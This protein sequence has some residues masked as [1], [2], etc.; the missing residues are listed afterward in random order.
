MRN[1]TKKWM[2]AVVVVSMVLGMYSVSSKTEA[3]GKYWLSGVSKPAGGTM[4]MYYK[5]NA[6]LI[7]GK[8]AIADIATRKSK[9]LL[10]KSS[11]K[12]QVAKKCKVYLYEADNVTSYSYKKWAKMRGY[13]RNDEISFIWVSLK[14]EGK[15]I[16][17]IEFSS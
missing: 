12:Y 5:G 2:I 11:Y 10:Q 15:K 3:K 16:T 6:V 1:I 13:K 7:R 8:V 14:V 4:R 9:A 17:R